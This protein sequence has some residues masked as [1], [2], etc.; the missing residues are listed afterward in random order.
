MHV[1]NNLLSSKDNGSSSNSRFILTSPFPAMIWISLNNKYKHATIFV[2][3]NTKSLAIFWR[4]TSLP[5]LWSGDQDKYYFIL[6]SWI[7]RICQ[8]SA[9][10]SAA[11]SCNSLLFCCQL[12]CWLA[13]CKRLSQRHLEQIT[14]EQSEIHSRNLWIKEIFFFNG[15]KSCIVGCLPPSN[16]TF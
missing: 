4:Q 7:G 5:N 8:Q 11:S 1:C 14:M 6:I 2:G 15:R 10:S 9:H 16:K 13:G 12:M 3:Q